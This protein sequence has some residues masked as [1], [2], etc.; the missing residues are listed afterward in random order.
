MDL[1]CI[2][3]YSIARMRKWK[4]IKNCGEFCDSQRSI[5]LLQ[6]EKNECATR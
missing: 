1:Q 3:D 5:T 2:T 6:E 4:I